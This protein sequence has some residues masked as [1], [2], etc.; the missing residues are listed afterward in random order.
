MLRRR[1]MMHSEMVDQFVKGFVNLGN[2]VVKL[3]TE[4]QIKAYNFTIEFNMKIPLYFGK[5]NIFIIFSG[6]RTGYIEVL[7]D[8]SFAVYRQ[9]YIP[10]IYNDGM[11][12]NF[13][14]KRESYEKGYSLSID[15]GVPSTYN[16]GSEN[17]GK[18]YFILEQNSEIY[19]FSI[20]GKKF[21]PCIKNGYFGYMCDKNFYAFSSQDI[22]PIY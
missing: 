1:M 8:N 3:N 9:L 18:L 16:V 22:V 4:E 21:K 19:K 13:V 5:R 12:H 7:Y 11:L 2:T 14:W 6:F 20:N 15:N 17:N 10:T